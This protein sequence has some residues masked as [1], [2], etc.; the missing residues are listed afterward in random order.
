[1]PFIGLQS[2]QK[3]TPEEVEDG[4]IVK[5]PKCSDSM[6]PRTSHYRKGHFVARHFWHFEHSDS[7]C[8]GG[9]SSEHEKMKSIALSKLKEEFEYDD[10]G[11]ETKIGK[12]KTDAYVKFPQPIYPYGKGI[13]VEV[14]YR[15][16]GKDIEGTTKDYMEEDYSVCWLEEEDYS[17]K[18]VELEGNIE[19]IWPNKITFL[20]NFDRNKFLD[21]EGKGVVEAVFPPRLLFPD[22]N[23]PPKS[24]KENEVIFDEIKLVRCQQ[25]E[26]VSKITKRI[27]SDNF[28]CHNCRVT[29]KE[30]SNKERKKKSL[31]SRSKT[32]E[33]VIKYVN[34]FG[35]Q[36]SNI[37]LPKK[38][39]IRKAKKKIKESEKEYIKKYREFAEEFYSRE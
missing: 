27:K 6:K 19:K 21:I 38:S 33:K 35:P 15:N 20:H 9:E 25:C 14:Q 3:V 17:K 13:A 8:G 5:C 10:A 31:L 32:L 29:K 2:D 7:H 22:I 36:S 1:M 26:N 34:R 12:S 4:E 16:K 30:L 11:L 39:S 28:L 23:F 24:I 37:K 18:D